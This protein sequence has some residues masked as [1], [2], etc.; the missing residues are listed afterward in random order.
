MTAVSTLKY[1][2]L[3]FI[4]LPKTTHLGD[5]LILTCAFFFF[6]RWRKAAALIFRHP[7]SHFTVTLSVRSDKSFKTEEV[8]K[9]FVELGGLV[10]KVK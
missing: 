4:I 5:A 9:G 8:M 1:N 2:D 7:T 6:E 3:Y 10:F